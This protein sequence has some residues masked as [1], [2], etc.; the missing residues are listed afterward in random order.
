MKDIILDKTKL[1]NGIYYLSDED[2]KFELKYIKLRK[3]ENR[4][5]SDEEVELLPYA[6]DKIP[7]KNEWKLR[8]KS[9]ERFI[10]YIQGFNNE[11]KLLDIGCGNGWFSS[12]LAKNTMIEVYAL[13][14]N[15]TELEQATRVF[16]TNN[17]KFIYGNIFENIFERSYFNII[18][19]NSSVQYFSEFTTLINRLFYFLSD[20]G[21]IHIIDSPFYNQKELASARE[22]SARYYNSTDFPEMAKHYHHHTFDELNIFDYKILYEPKSPA[23]KLMYIFGVKNSPFPWIRII[24]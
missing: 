23:V 11:L 7:H 13:D 5:Y 19:L 24:K 21:E 20:E 15:K 12:N 8:R 22:R 9:M 16:N 17:L 2:D 18:T 3:K 10:S 6:S 4:I 1:R 14:I